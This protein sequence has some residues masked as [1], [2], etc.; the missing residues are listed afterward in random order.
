MIHE[1]DRRTDRHR[2]TAI[3]AL[4]HSIARQKWKIRGEGTY[5]T[6]V[7]G[8]PT[9][10][11]ALSV[12]MTFAVWERFISITGGAATAFPCVHWI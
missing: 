1:R 2:A 5:C 10:L 9:G 6:S 3:A 4:M 11:W 8:L 12:F 7:L